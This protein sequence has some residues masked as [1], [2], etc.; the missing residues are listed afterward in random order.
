[1]AVP[2]AG[3]VPDGQ[4]QR[5]QAPVLSDRPTRLNP[6]SEGRSDSRPASNHNPCHSNGRSERRICWSTRSKVP[7]TWTHSHPAWLSLHLY[8]HSALC[9]A[10][11]RVQHVFP[12]ALAGLA[13]PTPTRAFMLLNKLLW[14]EKAQLKLNFICIVVFL[15]ARG[16]SRIKDVTI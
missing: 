14:G 9:R 7:H 10:L 13:P 16:R 4:L 3:R 2:P 8:Y 12:L 1:M 5:G 11:M 15:K 6:E